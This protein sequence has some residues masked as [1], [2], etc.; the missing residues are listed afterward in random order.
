MGAMGSDLG[1]LVGKPGTAKAYD[2]AGPSGPAC[3]TNLGVWVQISS[4]SSERVDIPWMPSPGELLF[5]E[6]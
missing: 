5:N 2:W 3:E 4:P 1:P 6:C